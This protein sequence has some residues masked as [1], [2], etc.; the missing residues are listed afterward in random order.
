MRLLRLPCRRLIHVTLLGLLAALVLMPGAQSPVQSA[1]PPKTAKFEL[2]P[3]DHVSI[4]GNTLADR[5]QHDGWVETYL[6]SRFP[7][8]D[9]VFRN[10]GF[11]ADEIDLKQRLRSA[12]FGSPDKWLNATKADVVFAFFG[13]N[14]SF[15]GETGVDKFKKELDSFVKYTVGQKYNGKSEARLVLFSPVAHEDLHDRNLPDGKDNN[16]RLEMYTKAMADVAKDNGVPFVDLFHATRDAYAKAEKP[17]TINGVHLNERGNEA[18]AQ[19]IDDALF[20]GAAVK[21]DAK[22][23]EKIRRAVV[24][25]NETWYSRYRTTDGYS[26]YGGR[27][28]EPKSVAPD[29]RNRASMEREM[30]ILDVM[31]ANRDKVVWA[32]AKG[33]D[34]KPDDSNTPPFHEVKTNK[35]GPLAGGAHLFLSGEEAIKKMTV[36][37]GLKV[38]LFADESMFPE[39][40]KPV[41]MAFD[42]KGRLWVAVWPTYPHFKPK[43]EMSDKILIFED[44]KGTGKADKMTVF[45]DGLHNPTGFDF[46]NGGV[47]VAQAPDIIFLK[48]SK[49][50][51]KADTRVRLLSGMDTA[52]THHTSNSFALDPG[53]ALYWQEGTFHHTQVETPYGPAVR[54]VNA[55]VYRYE[56]RSQKFDNYVTFGF[57]NPHGH[58]FDRWG[59][60]V[61][62]DGTGSQPYDGALFSGHLDYPAKHP[63]PP[64]IYQQR[65]RPCPGI[66]ILTSKHFPAE[67]QG[68]L[69]VGDVIQTQGILRY[70]LEEKGG[71][72]VGVEQELLLK[73]S[74]PN[75]RPSDLKVGPDGAIYFIDWQNPLIGHLQHNLRDPSRDRTH[76]RIYKITYEGREPSKSPAI[77][78]ESIEKLLD[79]LKSPEDRVRYR[80]KI[81]LGGRKSDDVIAAVKKWADGL[82]AKD[83]DYEHQMM[84]ALW[85]H[86]YHNVVNADL[87]KRMLSSKEPNARAAAT[88][89]LC[90]WRDRVP[91]ALELLKKQA[92][93]ESPRVRLEAIRAASFFTVPEA[94]E[95]VFITNDYATDEYIDFVRNET[96]KSIEPY[97]R[98][99]IA[100]NKTIPFTTPAGARYLLKNLT[101]D[102]LVKQKRSDAVYTEMLFRKGIR[103]EFRTEALAGLSK[104]Q[105][106]NELAVLLEAI[107]AQDGTKNAQDES[108]AFDLVRLLTNRDAAQLKEARP[109]LEKLAADAKTP[110]TRELGYVALIA[111]DGDV[112]KAWALALKSANALQDLVSAMPLIRDPSQRALMYS[113]VEPLIAGLP[114]DLKTDASKETKGRYVRIEL[115]GT[116]KTLTLAE[117]EV[118]SAGKNVA[119]QGSASQSSTAYGGEAS[120]AIDGNTSGKFGDGG[121][122][123]T[124]ENERN[125]W[126]EVDLKNDFAIEKIVIYNRTD[127]ELGKRLNNFSLIVLDKDRKVLFRKTKLVAPET[128]AAYEIGTEPPEKAIR[129]AAMFG[130]T[131]VRGK[132]S[133]AFKV[134]AGYARKDET[135]ADAVNA[136]LRIP[137][138]DW[139]KD[140]AKPLLD[141]LMAYVAKLPPAERTG[142]D[143]LNALQVADNLASLLPL[144]EAKA[145]RKQLGE[146]GVRVIRVATLPE[147]MSYDKDRVVVKAGKPFEIVFENTDM[148][149]HNLVVTQPGALEKIGLL[150][151]STAQEPGAFDRH[152]VPKAKEVLFSSKLLNPR[153]TQKLSLT[154]PDKPGV[155]P[156]VCTYPGHFRR[157]YAALYVVEDLDEYLA[158]AQAYLDKHPLDIKDDLLKFNRPRTEWKYDELVDEVK[159]LK[160][161]RS[162]TNAKY[163]FQM[164]NCVGCHKM[165]GAGNEFGPDLTKLDPKQDKLEEILRDVLEPSFRINEKYK[166][167]KFTLKSGQTKTGLLLDDKGDSYKII[168]NPLAKAE[169]IVIKK[170]AVDAKEESK[171]SIMPK[172]LLDRLTKEEILDLMA[173]VK[174]KGDAKHPLFQGGHDHGEHQ[175]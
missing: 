65:S 148:M 43:E 77:A 53:G 73:S 98:K 125:P 123:H 115:P 42:A 154:A 51:D 126:W 159:Q 169:P 165:N 54:C 22:L 20:P 157:M 105:K 17:L 50:G 102:E 112:D 104:S 47:I 111:A 106:K 28:D 174:A 110:L 92:A 12:N 6:H 133:D 68:N 64:Q 83:A 151:E 24:D 141:S 128:K 131:S 8:H 52:D 72:M 124:K 122:T 86:Q 60:D 84:E 120:K 119:R 147:Q 129:R 121:Q 140:E 116:S 4:I 10:L 82:D 59:R 75:F 14:E 97:F 85:L 55:G 19:I 94:I 5:M 13:Y 173:Y 29:Q 46:Y 38:T 130:L 142:D 95:V 109:D 37:K 100:E 149:P 21:R 36:A 118:Y 2:K 93:D 74:D 80:A 25:R 63:H 78:G 91:D 40:A 167:Y 16:K 108:V 58:V 137:V 76:G 44:T 161:G 143:A 32:V 48:D 150:A 70:K 18:V 117:V 103:D 144:T 79:V 71:S 15:A 30:E 164:A 138:K 162:F 163:V 160:G 170:D 56:P 87:L 113:K 172:G 152:Y 41:Q 61:V 26:I 88:R 3:G 9:L 156:I 158:D 27:A 69:L 67:W 45:A 153:E 1:D 62:V 155:Y 114:K 107:R 49:G 39:L 101:N 166:S 127:E 134:L 168:E 136:L 34:A 175:H 132:E 99:A 135:R 139:P 57:A 11:A 145:V 89:V 171:V 146:L 23:M 66:E 31:T 90:Y 33:K 35:P 96:M 7:E 81:E